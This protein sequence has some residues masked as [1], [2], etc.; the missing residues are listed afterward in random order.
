MTDCPCGS[1]KPYA[2]CCQ[3]LHLGHPPAT[4]DALM[5]SRYTAYVLNLEAYLLQ[6]WHPQTRPASLNLPD[7]PPTKWLGLAVKRHTTDGDDSAIVEFI[8]RY[9][10]GGKAHW[11][12]EI[13][14]FRSIDGRWF[15]LD[16]EHP[17]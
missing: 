3:P 7:N 6:T 11:L 2:A 12:H 10:V 4:A 17:S 13:S 1:G 15:Y 9:K 16:G 5:R 8:A 14:R